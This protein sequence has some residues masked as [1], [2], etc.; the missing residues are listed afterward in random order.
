MTESNSDSSGP[1][2]MVRGREAEFWRFLKFRFDLKYVFEILGGKIVGARFTWRRVR[3]GI[4]YESRLDRFYISNQGWW[5]E[6]ISKLQ[7]A[8]GSAFSDHD[9]ILLIFTTTAS[10]ITRG[11]ISFFKDNPAVVRKDDDLKRLETTWNDYPDTQV[12]YPL[13]FLL[14][15]QR[16]RHCYMNI[17]KTPADKDEHLALLRERLQQIKVSI[18][19]SYLTQEV[20]ELQ[21]LENQVRIVELEEAHHVRCLSRIKWLGQEMNLLDSFLPH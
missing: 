1:T 16:L 15:C 8:G 12:G 14:A 17:Q 9:P 20:E 5:L 3:N 19:D 11:K 18:S 21:D 10:L 13:R 7:H 2:P 4:L 6:G